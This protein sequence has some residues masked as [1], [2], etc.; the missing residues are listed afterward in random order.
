LGDA[1]QLL[2]YDLNPPENPGEALQ[3]KLYW[4]TLAAVAEDY[5]VFVHVIDKNG[6]LVAQADNEPVASL[7]PTGRWQPGDLIRDPYRVD[8]PA[9]LPSGIYT[10]NV[11][12]YLRQNGARLPA[13]A[14]QVT[15][16][17][18]LLTT[19]QWPPSSP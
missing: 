13:E 3:L 12:M 18:I 11:G 15:E 9:D 1:I 6:Q 10:I 16:N 14:D 7:A 8:W 4:E 2:G 17:A 5:D 19:F